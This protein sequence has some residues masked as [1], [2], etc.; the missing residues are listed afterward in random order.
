MRIRADRIECAIMR[1]KYYRIS[2]EAV[3]KLDLVRNS[4]LEFLGGFLDLPV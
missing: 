4:L 3:C 1:S 2:R